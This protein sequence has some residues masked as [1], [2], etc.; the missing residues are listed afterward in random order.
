MKDKRP[1]FLELSEDIFYNF[2]QIK[3]GSLNLVFSKRALFPVMKYGSEPEII[4]PLPRKRDNK[5][6][7]E[8]MLFDSDSN[9]RRNLW[10][11]FLA[12]I[13]HLAAHACVSRYSIYESWKKSKTEDVCLRVIDH[14]EDIS[15]ERYISHTDSEIWENMK[16]ID[17]KF[18]SETRKNYCNSWDE[19]LKFF[20][21]SNKEK[22]T[23]IRT[24]MINKQD[25]VILF[26]N[27]LYKNRGLLL[28]EIPPYYERHDVKQILK[29]EQQSPDFE[30]RGSFQENT[31]QLDELWLADEQFK[32][33]L[34]RRYKKNLKDLNFGT[35]TIPQGNFH[36]FLQIKEKVAPLLRRVRQQILMVANHFDEPKI[37]AMG[38]LNMQMAIQSIASEG[39]CVDVFERD[40]IRRV[41]Q[42]WVILIDNSA[43]MNLRFEQIKEFTVCIAEAA[44]DLTEKSDAWAL[45]SFSND[46]QILKDF[47]EKYDHEV[48]ARIGSLENNGLSLLP[49]AIELARRMLLDDLR[50]R[51]YIFIITDGHPSGYERINQHLA[52]IAKKLD[53]SGVSLIAIGVSKH[54]SKRFRNSMRGSSNLGQLV[55][56]FITA[57]KTVSSD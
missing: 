56:K 45:F 3:P 9:G 20:G 46:L 19:D 47:E 53:A 50:E 29:T 52:K 38:Y 18:M 44:N 7:F 31:V 14:I 40:E 23:K 34:L 35:I 54:T 25:D 17:L 49:D 32:S 55:A 10:C 41:E 48:Q 39:Q 6:L 30:P 26:A 57:Y 43:S 51:K 8:G 27:L 12:T 16:N 33:K 37:D 2:S 5:Y 13:Y 15:V 1:S 4:I 28:T 24:S 21:L 36:N 42:A 11:L 22:I